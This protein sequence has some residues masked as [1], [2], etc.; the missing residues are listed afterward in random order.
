MK[1]LIYINLA[2]EIFVLIHIWD[3]KY[4]RAS[5]S[6]FAFD[7]NSSTMFFNEFPAKY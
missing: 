6:G 4:K 3:G 7:P 2:L 1:T 5:L